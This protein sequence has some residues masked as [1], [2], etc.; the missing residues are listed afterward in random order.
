MKQMKEEK[1]ERSDVKREHQQR[2]RQAGRGT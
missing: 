1:Q 2:R